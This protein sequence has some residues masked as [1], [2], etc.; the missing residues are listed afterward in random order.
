M[1]HFQY[2]NQSLFPSLK[3]AV[4]QE[5]F[6]QG[7]FLESKRITFIIHLGLISCEKSN[8]T[9]HLEDSVSVVISCP[10]YY[11]DVHISETLAVCS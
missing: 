1:G 2:L 3:Y 11:L 4:S 10:F 7:W 5:V 6:F 8:I 9:R